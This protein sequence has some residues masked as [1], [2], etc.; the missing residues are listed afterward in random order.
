MLSRA[1]IYQ[2]MQ[3]NDN[4]YAELA[5]AAAAVT[6]ASPR[7]RATALLHG[8]GIPKT[9]PHWEEDI[10]QALAIP[11]IPPDLRSA[12]LLIRASFYRLDRQAEK[13]TADCRAIL[14]MPDIPVND[15]AAALTIIAEDQVSRYEFDA[16]LKGLDE[17]LTQRGLQP[18]TQALGYLMRCKIRLDQNDYPR[19]YADLRLAERIDKISPAMQQQVRQQRVLMDGR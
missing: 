18:D 19:A 12:A 16:A 5:A 1:S 15:R 13:S 14:A 9:E 10:A 2:S 17:A 8:A 7:H 3:Q 11:D 6:D 4:A